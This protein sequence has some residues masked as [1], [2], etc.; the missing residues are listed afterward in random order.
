MFEV[1]LGLGD[2][3]DLWFITSERRIRFR[4][5]TRVLVKHNT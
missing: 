3:E 1:C 4:R 2:F 5:M